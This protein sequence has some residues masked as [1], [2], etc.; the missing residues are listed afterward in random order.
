[1]GKRERI[2]E[3]KQVSGCSKNC[4]KEMIDE[5]WWSFLNEVRTCLIQAA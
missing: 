2:K 4:K 3:T 5:I 1:M